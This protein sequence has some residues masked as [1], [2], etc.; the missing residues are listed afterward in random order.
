MY[1]PPLYNTEKSRQLI[2]GF[3][4]Y[5]NN[6]VISE[7]SFYR[8][9]NM[10]SDKHPMLSPRNKRAFFNVTG[11]RLH[12][13]FSKGKIAYVNNGILYYGGE[14]VKGLYFPDISGDRQF[15]S[16]GAKLLV[17]PD[18]VY[19]NTENFSDY[20]SL[21][22][23]FT[24][25]KAECTLCRGDGDLYEGYT[26]S[27]TPP[28]NASHG[29]LWVDTSLTKHALKQYSSETEA[30]IELED[31]FI[32]IN[33]SGIGGNF[34]QYDGVTL[35]GFSAAGIDG[36]HIIYDKGDDYIVV[37]GMLDNNVTIDNTFSVER[38]LPDFD[39]V[40]ESGNRL[41]GCSSKTN[42]IFASKLGDPANFFT[43][44]GISTD[45][46]AVT[47]G[48]DGDFT[49]AVS[50]RGYVLFFKESCVHKLYGFNPPYT[51][52]TS[53]IRGVQK[54]SQKS[55]C[56]LNETL[57]YKSP[58]GVCA[59]EGGI[60]V[61]ISLPLGN[62]YYTDA[63]AGAVGNKYYI[64]MTNVDGKR[65]LFTYDESKVLWHREGFFD[66]REFAEN[67]L[68]LYFI[69]N[70][71]E[72]LVLGLADSVNKFGNFLGELKGYSV[73]NDFGWFVE[74]GLWGTEL[75]DNKYYSNIRIRAIGSQGASLKVYF[76]FNSDGKWIKQF[77]KAITKTGS[78]SM[79][80]TT[81][82]CDHMRVRIEGKGDVKILSISR[83]IENGSELNV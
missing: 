47:V 34:N 26:V 23:V 60:P 42:E 81:P 51:V 25:V 76:Q 11:E 36:S 30:W 53:Y 63:V 19:L 14:A 80:F 56:R 5:E 8:E 69:A 78:F 68:N 37:A 50:Y 15:V 31:K 4:G 21:E 59:Y 33:C 58:N 75:P 73:E 29:D 52:T 35:S 13:L 40:C 9:E 7:S 12:G 16:M 1:K 45:S 70:V 54:G 46:Y 28:Q 79:P 17:F 62:N 18:K 27:N 67:N 77:E 38:K 6:L 43:Y 61:D 66:V 83:N 64:C 74:T 57:Y 10:S 22:A 32:R 49:G 39:F 72:K 55:L 48:S 65:E 82:R 71:N 44:M 41:W 24:G 3:G 2:S 20:G